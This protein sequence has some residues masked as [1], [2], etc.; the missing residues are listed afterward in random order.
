MKRN[1]NYLARA[2]SGNGR[3]FLLLCVIPTSLSALYFSCV[4]DDVYVSESHFIVRNQQ[5]QAS[6]GLSGFLQ[7]SGLA[8]ADTETYSVQDFLSSRDALQQLLQ[9]ENLRKDFSGLRAD[10]LKRFPGLIYHDT[11]EDLWLYYKRFILETDLD[12]TS[13]ILTLI[14]RAF[15]AD[16]AHRINEALLRESEALINRMNE[17]AQKD[18][19]RFATADVETA[20][21]AQTA[22]VREMA[23]FRNRTSVYDPER[24]SGLQLER[25][26]SVN[27]QLLAVGIQLAD[28]RTVAPASPQI[29][30]LESRI[31]HLT[32]SVSA[33]DAR[34]AGSDD[35]LSNKAA[36]F[37]EVALHQGFA[38]KRLALSLNSLQQAR[39]DA[40]HQQLYLE[41]I[42]E[43]NHPDVAME[44]RRLRNVVGTL[45]LSLIIF[46]I[47]ALL[48]ASVK[49]HAE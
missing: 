22:A 10:G 9:T 35:A 12:S 5:H 11:F 41:R 16:D 15:T 18:L 2:W 45:I 13:E 1:L 40:L 39:E 44:P 8:T 47:V 27:R 38:E 34:V 42:S 48:S 19:I 23:A 21:R 20:E 24:Q 33:E 31:R 46:G 43:P 25:V 30:L 49:E 3:L 6:A 36:E 17:R 26:E 32:R 28:L 29:P 37:A 7:S 4:A 14:V